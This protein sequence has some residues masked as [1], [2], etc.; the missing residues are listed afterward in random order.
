M[1]KNGTLLLLLVSILLWNCKDEKAVQVVEETPAVETVNNEELPDAT[2][3]GRVDSSLVKQAEFGAIKQACQLISREWVKKNIPGFQN[4]D[5]NLQNRTSPDGNASACQCS[6]VTEAEQK[7][8][9]V[10]YRISAGNLQYINNLITNGLDRE[11]SYDIPPY[12]E[13]YELGQRAAFSQYNGNLAWVMDNGL[14]LYMLM[15]PQS[16]ETMKG[17]F[18]TLYSVA[19]M[20]SETVNKYTNPSKG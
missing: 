15:Y 3:G 14:Y 11:D 20:I 16:K 17:P 8:F 13:V 7:V 18:N 19:P 1:S 2:D 4:G 9:V 12:K 10:G 6:L 5:I